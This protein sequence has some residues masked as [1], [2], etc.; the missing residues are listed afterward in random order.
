[1]TSKITPTLFDFDPGK[2]ILALKSTGAVS[3]SVLT[4]SNRLTLVE[5]ARDLTFEKAEETVGK[6]Q[7]HQEMEV[8]EDVPEG[9]VFRDLVDELGKSLAEVFAGTADTGTAD[10]GSTDTDID[11]G[12][13]GESVDTIDGAGNP[14]PADF[15]FNQTNLQRYRAGS[16]GISPH[17]DG[18]RFV[19]LIGILV[20][21]GSGLFAT[22]ADREGT[23][24]VRVPADPGMLV[25]LRAP[26]FAGIQRRPFHFVSEVKE[27]RLVVI[28]RHLKE[29]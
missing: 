22:C 14:I 26:G 28:M 29:Q 27:N 1:M 3:F 13:T 6:Y 11:T 15:R 24:P 17:R 12:S 8:C 5:A 2:T 19:Y 10:T 20:L 16:S 21:T 25:L 7:V 18:K 23:D 4:E 9:S